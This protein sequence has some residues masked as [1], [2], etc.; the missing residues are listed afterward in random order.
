L[1]WNRNFPIVELTIDVNF[2]AVRS[3]D[4]E[5]VQQVVTRLGF[6]FICDFAYVKIWNIIAV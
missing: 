6:L 5:K 1:P 3:E 4:E 2:R